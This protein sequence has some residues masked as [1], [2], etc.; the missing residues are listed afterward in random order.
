[1]M[2]LTPTVTV[3][4]KFA[5]SIEAI[6]R[7]AT[8]SELNEAPL[9]SDWILANQ[10][11]PHFQ[12]VAQGHPLLPA[13]PFRS[14]IALFIAPDLSHAR[15]L[16]RWYRLGDMKPPSSSRSQNDAISTLDIVALPEFF[17]SV[18]LLLQQTAHDLCRTDI[19]SRIEKVQ[20]RK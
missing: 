5:T 14:S 8:D 12:G 4:D 7:G 11:F 17:D 16:S 18:T 2:E 19:I 9:L 15:T 13:G 1:M 6:Y 20:M 10:G 3:L